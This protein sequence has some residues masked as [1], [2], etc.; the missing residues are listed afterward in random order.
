MSASFCYFFFILSLYVDPLFLSFFSFS[1][2]YTWLCSLT[3]GLSANFVFSSPVMAVIIDKVFV[4]LL[5]RKA[6]KSFVFNLNV[7]HGKKVSILQFFVM[8]YVCENAWPT[9]SLPFLRHFSFPWMLSLSRRRPYMKEKRSVFSAEFLF[10]KK[11][12]KMT[13]YNKKLFRQCITYAQ[14]NSLNDAFRLYIRMYCG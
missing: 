14:F 4:A 12:S 3:V 9:F 11:K 13:E 5:S 2:F 6:V 1:L 7:G 10:G 8:I